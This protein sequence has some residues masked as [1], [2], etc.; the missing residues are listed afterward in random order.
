MDFVLPVFVNQ[1]IPLPCLNRSLGH[2]CV[3][4]DLILLA[5]LLS[6]LIKLKVNLN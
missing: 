6:E 2:N 3:L 1:V 4:H 5:A